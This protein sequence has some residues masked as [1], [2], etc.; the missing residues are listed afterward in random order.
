M[1]RFSL[2]WYDGFMKGTNPFLDFVESAVDV[3]GS[4]AACFIFA[5]DDDEEDGAS[6]G[7]NPFV[8]DP[9]DD[10]YDYSH[11]GDGYFFNEATRIDFIFYDD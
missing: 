3:I 2:L 7:R 11:N 1:Q 10:D 5:D 4:M 9:F 8:Y 6:E